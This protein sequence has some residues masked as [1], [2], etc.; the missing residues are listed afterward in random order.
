MTGIAKGEL[1]RLETAPLV[2]E[3]LEEGRAVLA[4]LWEEVR[5][6]SPGPTGDELI[7]AARKGL[8]LFRG[9]MEVFNACYLEEDAP[10]ERWVRQALRSQIG[11]AP[12]SVV[13]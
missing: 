8:E 5:S 4:W 3:A 2:D 12:A 6:D 11:F 9:F 10:G 13:E 1:L 7:A